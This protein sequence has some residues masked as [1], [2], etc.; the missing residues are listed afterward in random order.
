MIYSIGSSISGPITS[1][2]DISSCPGN[3]VIAIAS[4]N[5]ELR[6]S[7]VIVR[8][9]YSGYVKLIFSDTSKSI[10]VLARKNMINGMNIVMIEFR[11]P[12][13][14]S[15]WLANMQ[16]T[17]ADKNQISS[18][19]K[20]PLAFLFKSS[21]KANLTIWLAMN[22]NAMTVNMEYASCV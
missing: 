16:N 19:L 18:E 3:D 21:F 6:A 4:A 13:N 1:A 2:I 8:L 15:P 22:G 7:V 17:A 5:G 9:A 14:N 20:M 11:L 10:M 12:N